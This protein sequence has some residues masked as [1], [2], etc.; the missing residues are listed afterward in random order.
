MTCNGGGG[1]SFPCKLAA[2]R[3]SG[4]CTKKCNLCGYVTVIQH[5]LCEKRYIVKLENIENFNHQPLVL[6][7]RRKM[8]LLTFSCSSV[9][10]RSCSC[11]STAVCLRSPLS[12]VGIKFK[13]LSASVHVQVCPRSSL[14][15]HQVL[16]CVIVKMFDVKSE[17]FAELSRHQV[18]V[19]G[20]ILRQ[21]QNDCKR[22]FP[23]LKNIGP[24]ENRFML[25]A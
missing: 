18:Q 22:Y 24:S 20:H 19:Q 10:P 1:E 5:K 2:E 25:M 16:S 8:M 3:I 12:W 7:R 9:Q 14:S 21:V 11:P 4:S 13:I 23:C 15:W 17:E 6:T